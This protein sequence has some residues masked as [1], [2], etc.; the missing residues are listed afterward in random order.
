MLVIFSFL[1]ETSSARNADTNS[2]G[3]DVALETCVGKLGPLVCIVDNIFDFVSWVF[4]MS[5]MKNREVI[6]L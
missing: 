5:G 3:I 2:G 4:C 6:M 1:S